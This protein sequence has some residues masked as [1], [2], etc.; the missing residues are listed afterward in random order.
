MLTLWCQMLD[1]DVDLII[2]EDNE[3]TEKVVR[4]GYSQ[5]CL[6]E[7]VDLQ[8]VTL[9]HVKTEGHVQTKGVEAQKWANDIHPLG[10]STTVRNSVKANMTGFKMEAAQ[11]SPQVQTQAGSSKHVDTCN[12]IPGE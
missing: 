6:K 12:V 11:A 1:R 3:A 9:Q 7:V 10:I 5:K 2:F 4:S 8:N